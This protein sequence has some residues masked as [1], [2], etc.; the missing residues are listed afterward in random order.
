MVVSGGE[1][2]RGGGKMVVSGGEGERGGGSGG[3]GK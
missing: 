1:G 2:R 3:R